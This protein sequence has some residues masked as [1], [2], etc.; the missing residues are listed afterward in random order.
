M[1]TSA[2]LRKRDQLLDFVRRILIAYASVQV[3]IGIGSIASGL[4]HDGS[5]IDAVVKSWV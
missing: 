1:T 5:D 4:A 2:T 3:V